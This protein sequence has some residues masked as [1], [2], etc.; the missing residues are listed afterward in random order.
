M[1]PE[2]TQIWSAN[3]SSGLSFHELLLKETVVWMDLPWSWRWWDEHG[4]ETTPYLD[5]K[6]C[7]WNF[8]TWFAE[9]PMKMK[10]KSTFKARKYIPQYEMG[11]CTC[12]V[13]PSKPTLFVSSTSTQPANRNGRLRLLVIAR[14]ALI[15][16]S[17]KAD[18]F[19]HF[20]G[21]ISFR[22]VR[23]EVGF[24]TTKY[25]ARVSYFAA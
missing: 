20:N 22:I 24:A 21:E 23:A 6:T 8:T 13:T 10:S 5:Q 12:F 19:L 11:S 14:L 15:Q 4:L 2:S 16:I 25:P 18:W 3:P 1:A 17:P 7:E 9:V